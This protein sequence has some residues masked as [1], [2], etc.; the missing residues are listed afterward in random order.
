M[1]GLG[2]S[3]MKGGVAVALELVRELAE[4]DPGPVDVA[5]LLFG[6]EELPPQDN[7]LPALFDAC[8]LV[9]EA[10]LAVAARADRPRRSRPAASATSSRGVTF[11]GRS[12]HSAR[13]WLA[14]NALAPRD[15]RALA[16]WPPTSDAR[17]SID[18]LPFCEVVSVTRLEGGHR[19]QRH[20][21]S[22]GGD[23]QPPLPTRPHAGG[24]RGRTCARSCRRTR[25]VEIVGNSPPGAVVRDAPLVRRA[26]RGR[27]LRRSSRSRRG[28]TSP[29]SPSRGIAA[30][31][32][33]PGATR[34]AHAQDERV[35]IAALV[36]AY[37]ACGASPSARL[38]DD[39]PV[40]SGRAAL[41]RPARHGHV[42]VRPAQPGRRGAARPGPRGHRLRDGR[43]ARADRPGDPRRRFAT[44]SASAW[45]I[46][47]RPGSRSFARRSP[48]GSAA[49]SASR[50][51]PT[52]TSSRRSARRRRS[53][54]S[55]RSC[56]TC[57]AGATRS[58]SRSRAIRSPDAA[59]AFAGARVAELPLLE[60][61]G[62][63]PALDA[64]PEELWRRTALVWL[65]S[66]NNPTG[67]VAPLAVPR[68]PRRARARARLR[69]RVGRGVHGA[70]VRG[71]AALRAPAR[72]PAERRGVQHA[73]Q[74]VVDDRLPERLRRRRPRADRRAQAVP[75]ERRHGAAGVRP[76]GLGRRLGRRGARRPRP[77]VVRA[78]AGS[79]CSTS[80][81]ARAC[82]T[83]AGRRR[84]TS[85]SRCPAARRRRATPRACSRAAS[86]SRPARSSG[87]SGEGYVR[88]ALVPTEDECARAA[89]ILED[90]L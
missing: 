27:R 3:D 33:G 65:N 81:D 21:R 61:H 7:P 59:R 10:A 56:S 43:P 52:S 46:P 75:P 6:R 38:P 14:D 17:R 77:R 87:P 78:K 15:R 51:I 55:P 26:A 18:G 45:A 39:R 60:E 32:F 73:L 82:A 62:F 9:H 80:S 89:A 44:A 76:A 29:T 31:N 48:A 64:V 24:G 8:P 70:L 67:A 34:Y 58:S 66:P 54:R 69:A 20:A 23:A 63:L 19:G 36:R 42:P 85:G 30:V 4:R 88:Y 25:R 37:V 90:V 72:R 12:G 84:C 74:A 49:A 28:R 79:C 5:L 16:A 41:A 47:R 2:A 13:P 86:S 83:P 50:S 40:A 71:S 35:E 53:S 1:H 22:G 11:H 57:P 68:A